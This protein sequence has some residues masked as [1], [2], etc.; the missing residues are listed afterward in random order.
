MRVKIF[1]HYTETSKVLEGQSQHLVNELLRLYPWLHRS[2]DKDLKSLVARLNHD[3]A[4]DVAVEGEEPMA[5]AEGRNLHGQGE[6][7]AAMMGYHHKLLRAM[8]AVRFLSGGAPVPADKVRQALWEAD[9]DAEEAALLAAGM[10]VSGPNLKAL[11]AIQ[12]MADAKKAEAEPVQAQSVEPGHPDAADT[13][14]TVLRAF[15]DHFVLPVEL[16][17]KHSK[18]SL[19]ARDQDTGE[20]WLLK[21]GSGGQTPA[22]GAKQ[23]PSSQSRR[24]AAFWHMADA[25]HLGDSIPRADLLIIDGK[26]YAAI[27]LLPWTYNVLDK[28]K[29]DDPG[30]PRNLLADY[31]KRGVLHRWA[32]LDFVLGNPDRHAN[33]L[34]VKDGD[35]KLIDH[36]S[37]MAGEGFD[38]AHDRYSFTPYYLRAW[39]PGKFSQLGADE[40]LKYMP[41]LDRQAEENFKGWLDGLHATDLDRILYRYGVNP[42]PAKERLAKLKALAT[43]KA[44]DQAINEAWVIT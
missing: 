25:W 1:N 24:E 15:R 9:G 42:G 36:G 43:G 17:G 19:L 21:P 29:K 27:H 3:Q 34:M 40:K 18:G 31:M 23:D 37:A 11:R 7:V 10:E 13:A 4:Y 30:L 2:D 39:A 20:T 44:A 35:V 8:D 16:G 14:D 28:L 33:N 5:K 6:V 22:A 41:R 12:D 32:V 38:P 26:E